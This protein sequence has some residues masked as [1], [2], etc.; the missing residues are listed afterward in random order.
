MLQIQDRF[1]FPLPLGP[2]KSCFRVSVHPRVSSQE[3]QSTLHCVERCATWAFHFQEEEA[4]QKTVQSR[5]QLLTEGCSGQPWGPHDTVNPNGSD[6]PWHFALSMTAVEK[7]LECSLVPPST[8]ALYGGILLN[9]H[10]TEQTLVL[11]KKTLVHLDL[12]ACIQTTKE[13]TVSAGRWC[14]LPP[15]RNDGFWSLVPG[16]QS[17][18]V[19]VRMNELWCLSPVSLD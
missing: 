14:V 4:A 5:I 10:N 8:A 15:P 6:G 17:H 12:P 1:F 7:Q 18:S 11:M 16:R 3:W 13:K 9:S 2:L 19:R